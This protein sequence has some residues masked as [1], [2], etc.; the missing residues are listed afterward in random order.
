MKPKISSLLGR[1]V[2]SEI[3]TTTKII[4]DKRNKIYHKELDKEKKQFMQLLR[5]RE[6]WCNEN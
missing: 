4:P 6:V 2:P 1:A 5:T 3:S